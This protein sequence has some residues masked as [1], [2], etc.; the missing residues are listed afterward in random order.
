MIQQSQKL[1]N[2][3]NKNLNSIKYIYLTASGGPFYGKNIKL[4][5]VTPSQ[6]IKHP[7][8]QM[9]KIR[10]EMPIKVQ[11]Q[12]FQEIKILTKHLPK[13]IKIE[14]T[15]IKEKSKEH[16]KRKNKQRKIFKYQFL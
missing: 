1:I 5:K 16:Y 3:E 12:K 14:R 13:L 11:V 9:G 15:M 2:F 6:A 10:T 4:S 8:W 7:N